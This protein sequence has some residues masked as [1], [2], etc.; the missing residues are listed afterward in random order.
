MAAAVG[1]PPQA[2]LVAAAAC[3]LF[4]AVTAACSVF[5]I[6]RPGQFDRPV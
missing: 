4:A 3:G 1:L 2:N 6:G 5:W